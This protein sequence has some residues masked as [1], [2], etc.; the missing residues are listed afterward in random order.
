MDKSDLWVDL[1]PKFY[2]TGHSSYRNVPGWKNPDMPPN[3]AMKSTPLL[4]LHKKLNGKIVPFS[5]WNMPI[6]F[7][8]V[9]QEHRAVRESVGVFDVSHMGEIELQ[10]PDA[11]KFLQKLLTNDIAS[12][13]N[14]A[15]LYSLMCYDHGGVVDDLLVHRFT[16]NHFFLCVNAGNTDADFQW[17]L[18]QSQD[19]DLEV[20]NISDQTAQLAVQGRQAQELLQTLTDVPL[21]SLKYYHFLE[22]KVHQVDS[23]I[24]RT[25]YTG[26]DGFEIYFDARHAV[27]VYQQILSAGRPFGLQPIGLGARDTLRLEM[28][29]ALYGH[30][31]DDKMS[32]L[33][34]RLGWVIKWNK[35]IP[36]I[37]QEPLQE[38]KEAGLPRKLVGIRLLERG[39]PRSPY[40]VLQDG[41]PVGEVT[42]GTFSPSL[43]VGVALCYVPT[44]LAG[45]G[46]RLEIEIRDQA[47]PAE[48]VA[49][50]FVPS[51]VKKN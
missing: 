28:G 46:T 15:I 36:F 33:E 49:V 48:V 20:R 38:Q 27:P 42:S 11:Q 35:E 31:I 45:V 39:V 40:R 3:T 12:L 13:K 1:Q 7:A 41:K 29:Y 43:N 50:P 32:P 23:I 24:A 26:E 4:D 47:V 16:E 8:G 18:N 9:M 25:G 37:G 21:A 6:Q 44:E 5:G 34:A 51:H 2:Y 14:G 22:G 30:E 10:G 19:Y 17:V